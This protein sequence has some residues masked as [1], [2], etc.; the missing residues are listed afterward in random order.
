LLYVGLTRPR[1][2]VLATG[3][4][5]ERLYTPRLDP[6][7]DEDEALESL[8]TDRADRVDDSATG[9]AEGMDALPYH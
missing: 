4:L 7:A 1:H 8:P 6:L 5:P 3:A 2:A 9:V